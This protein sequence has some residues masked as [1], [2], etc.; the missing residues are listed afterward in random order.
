MEMATEK[1]AANILLKRGV[2]VPVTAPL[3]LR[4]FGKKTINLVVS[5]PTTYILIS[6][7]EKYLSMRIENTKDLTLPESFIL[8]KNHAKTMS[9]IVSVCILNNE[10]KLW[11]HKFL[12]SF[13]RKRLTAEELSY[14]FHLIIIYGGVEDFINTIR[15]MEAVRITKLMNLSPEEKM[16]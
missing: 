2:N 8:L 6:I 4:L 3:F 12:A 9:E 13:I 15:L 1:K 16:S 5:A 11:R 10:K 7:A 14:L